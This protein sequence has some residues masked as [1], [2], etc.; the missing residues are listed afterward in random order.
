MPP[1]KAAHK[2]AKKVAKKAAKKSPAKGAGKPGKDLRRAY[3]HMGR[4]QVLVTLLDTQQG[5]D[6]HT[7]VKHAERSLRA[8]DARSSA[9]LLRGAEHL[10]FGTIALDAAPDETLSEPVLTTVQEEYEHLR[11]R[12]AL[13]REGADAPR[14]V[15]AIAGRMGKSAAAAM[16]RKLYRAA[17]EMARGA[18]ALAQV[19]GGRDELPGKGTTPKR[20]AG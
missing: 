11:E 14:A 10:A 1:K 20:I 4:V 5:K 16:K 8:G 19:K 13:G 7:L 2:I 18:D 9:D 3:E 6:V 15:A 17:M 12:A